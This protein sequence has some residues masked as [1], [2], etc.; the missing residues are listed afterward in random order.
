MKVSDEN[1]EKDINEDN[2]IEPKNGKENNND[3]KRTKFKERSLYLNE[4]DVYEII[5]KLY[6]YNFFILDTS[7]YDINIAKGKVEAFDL[8]NQLLSYLEKGEDTQKILEKDYNELIK[9]I[10]EKILNNIENMKMFF[11]TLNNFR[12]KAKNLFSLKLYEI[13]I[14]IYN[15]TLDYLMKNTD[16]DLEDLMIIL[17]QT[18]YKIIE[19]KKVYLCQD[20]KSHE[21]YKN[22]D[23]WERN[24]INK[25]E[26]EFQIKEKNAKNT[27][28][29]LTKERIEESI[30]AKLLPFENIMIEFNIPKNQVIEIVE[31]I[32]KKFECSESLKEQA[33][34]FLDTNSKDS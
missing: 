1:K 3:I 17:S 29:I 6:S 8:S 11:V 22:K 16:K 7:E 19:G 32:L 14:Y 13:I 20:I 34:S 12:A 26:E 31:R 27:N 23:F 9:S 28:I 10:D 2:N 30:L 15:K 4:R 21:I 18:Y 25:I 33:L 5:S 24:I